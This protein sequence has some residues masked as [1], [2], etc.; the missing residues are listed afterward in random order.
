LVWMMQIMSRHHFSTEPS[1]TK[2]KIR[3]RR[4]KK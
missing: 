2:N 4:K 3:K 1:G